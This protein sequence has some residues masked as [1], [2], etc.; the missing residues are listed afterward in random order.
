MANLAETIDI[1]RLESKT[2]E[3]VPLWIGVDFD[4][5]LVVQKKFPKIGP[6]VEKMVA[7]VRHWLKDGVKVKGFPGIVRTVKVFTA[8]ASGPQQVKLLQA[9]TKKY[10]GKTLEVTNVKDSGCVRIVDNISV[11][12][13]KDEGT[14]EHDAKVEAGKIKPHPFKGE[15]NDKGEGVGNCEECGKPFKH[16]A[17][18]RIASAIEAGGPGSGWTTEG[19]HISHKSQ[20]IRELLK[21]GGYTHAKTEDGLEHWERSSVDKY[22]L[23]PTKAEWQRPGKYGP[24]TGGYK[25]LLNSGLSNPLIDKNSMLKP[26]LD[27]NQEKLGNTISSSWSKNADSNGFN[28]MKAIA[29]SNAIKEGN[30]SYNA[31]KGK[32]IY[33][34]IASKLGMTPTELVSSQYAISR[35]LAN[36]QAFRSKMADKI[37]DVMNGSK[38][39]VPGLALEYAVTQKYFANK[40]VDDVKL[41]RGLSYGDKS[42]DPDG[43]IVR[44]INLGKKSPGPA[45]ISTK[46]AESWTDD[47]KVADDF[48]TK[49][50][51]VSGVV[52]TADVKTG[53]IFSC[54]LSNPESFSPKRV[55]ASLEKE[56]IVAPPSKKLLVSLEA[57]GPGS[58]RTSTG[59]DTQEKPH[60]SSKSLNQDK[61]DHMHNNLTERGYLFRYSAPSQTGTTHVYTKGDTQKSGHRTIVNVQEEKSGKHSMFKIKAMSAGGPGSGRHPQAKYPENQAQ[62]DRAHSHFKDVQMKYKGSEDKG[63]F[64]V[65]KYENK[66]GSKATLSEFAPGKIVRGFELSRKQENNFVSVPPK[67][68]SAGGPGSG[69]H[70]WGRKIK[71]NQAIS[72]KNKIV[73]KKLQK[74]ALRN[75]VRIAR[76]QQ[77]LAED[78]IQKLVAKAVGG[79]IYGRDS[80]PVDVIT[81]DSKGRLHGIEVKGVIL[82]KASARH[83][84][85]GLNQI[86]MKR[87]AIARKIA[88]AKQSKA[89][90][91]TVIVDIRSGGLKNPSVYHA[92]GVSAYTFGNDSR[93]GA[94]SVG[95]GLKG[96][97]KAVRG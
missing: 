77:I 96:L 13:K 39:V 54:Y 23:D 35:W 82:Q 70:P 71:P 55:V 85:G 34:E 30:S 66:L 95:G 75:P 52:A 69:R 56:Y 27:V 3:Q 15:K 59:M 48:K 31:A 36:D 45:V 22:M 25:S 4:G 40:G 11:R 5:T 46:Q 89:Y 90:L 67:K 81:R 20:I 93:A 73:D 87:E 19:G 26:T 62:L 72:K 79:K 63:K 28:M 42:K 68:V 61:L 41:Y 84:A 80:E 92:N 86:S 8:R 58:G 91:H 1:L 97:A 10:L 88:W 78:K 47:K 53:N 43:E 74:A 32:G 44:A 65:H 50:S 49:W 16:K 24:S 18:W 38:K 60:W 21:N 29:W 94:K 2:D 14:I 6:P 12:V 51:T 7:R 64:T 33:V 17:H 83:A 9:W 76:E 57:G 37:S